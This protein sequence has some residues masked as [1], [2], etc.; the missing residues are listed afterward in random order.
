MK[1]LKVKDYMTLQAVTFTVDM[2][3]SAALDKVMK[4]LV[5]GGPVIN[6]KKKSSAFYPNK[7]YSIS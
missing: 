6:E 2:S 4:S 7:T 5:M 3:L 1:S